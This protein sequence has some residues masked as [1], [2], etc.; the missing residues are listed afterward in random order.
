MK[1]PGYILSSIAVAGVLIIGATA[2][3]TA[4]GGGHGF[5]RSG[6]GGGPAF[7][8]GG[9]GGPAFVGSVA[10]R[11]IRHLDLDDAQRDQVRRIVDAAEPELRA[12]SDTMQESR[13]R[14]RELAVAD[15]FDAAAMRASADQQGDLVADMIVLGTGIMRDVR[16][17]LT[18]EQL[19]KLTSELEGRRGGRWFGPRR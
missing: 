5:G 16:A 11:L 10:E 6:F 19:E 4:S 12:L 2:I 1:R 9:F 15:G 3:A 8:H 17:V 14:L 7:A 13:E 18:P